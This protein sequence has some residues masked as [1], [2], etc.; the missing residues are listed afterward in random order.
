M[1]NQCNDVVLDKKNEP[2]KM[3]CKYFNDETNI[4]SN[5]ENYRIVRYKKT[6]F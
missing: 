2:I 6:K 5:S 4:D 3:T 1:T